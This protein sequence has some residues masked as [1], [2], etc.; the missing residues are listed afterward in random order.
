MVTTLKFSIVF[1]QGILCFHFVPGLS[2]WCGWSGPG[3]HLRCMY[4][5]PGSQWGDW[6]C[7]PCFERWSFNYCTTWEDLILN[8][9]YLLISCVWIGWE[10]PRWLSRKES[11]CPCRRNKRSGFNF[12]VGKIPWRREWQLTPKLLPGISHGQM[13]MVGCSP[14]GHKELNMPEHT[15]TGTRYGFFIYQVAEV[16]LTSFNNLTIFF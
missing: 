6:T 5:V 15:H 12:W 1:E 9:V 16:L 11:A 13:N 3:P 10:L 8:R 2:K 14:C 4:R 7:I